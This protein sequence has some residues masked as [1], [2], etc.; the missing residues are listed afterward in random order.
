V[1][2]SDLVDSV[3]SQST[4]NDTSSKDVNRRSKP[5][6]KPA[7]LDQQAQLFRA[8][9][10]GLPL[11]A[12]QL[13]GLSAQGNLGPWTAADGSSGPQS[14]G[15]QQTLS[16]DW[17]RREVDVSMM[18]AAQRSM[19]QGAIA[20]IQAA[21]GPPAPDLSIAELIEK[22]VR[23]ALAL[24]E[25]RRTSAGG[26]VRLELSDAVLPGTALSLRRTADGWQLSATADNKQSLE[27]LNEFAPSLVQR[28]AQASLGRLEISIE[29]PPVTAGGREYP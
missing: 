1:T 5:R 27:R 16:D 29:A 20:N 3:S 11:T 22:H 24:Q 21:S 15:L 8:L 12:A 28:F 10:S 14:D 25:T 7:D 2:V 18:M 4:Q 26:E 6:H 17:R 9:M 13:A 19:D 23:R